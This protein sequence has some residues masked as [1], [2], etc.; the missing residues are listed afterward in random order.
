MRKQLTRAAGVPFER[1]RK[2]TRRRVFL[3]EMDKVV[4]R[5]R[6]VGLIEPHYPKA[7]SQGGRPTIGIERILRIHCL[8][9]WFSLSDPAGEEAL[10]DSASV[11]AFAGIHLGQELVHD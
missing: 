5:R 4:P 8:Q 2:S 1:Y 3:A 10:Y 7:G 11:R 9:H 6:R